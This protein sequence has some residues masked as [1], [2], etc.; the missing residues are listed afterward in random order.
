MVVVDFVEIPPQIFLGV[1][2]Y[3]Q[4]PL[5]RCRAGLAFNETPKLHDPR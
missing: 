3:I 1:V 2:Q 4:V 5:S